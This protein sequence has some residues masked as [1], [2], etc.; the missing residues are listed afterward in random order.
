MAAAARR[1]FYNNS[2]TVIIGAAAFKHELG[3]G[4][5]GKYIYIYS[6]RTVFFIHYLIS[7][8]FSIKLGI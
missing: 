8:T 1:R 5:W 7:G 4:V 2:F 6:G 3:Y